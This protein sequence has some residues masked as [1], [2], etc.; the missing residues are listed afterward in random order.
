MLSISLAHQDAKVSTL[1]HSVSHSASD[2][3]CYIK[4]ALIIVTFTAAMRIA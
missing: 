1:C 3:W 4:G 2:R